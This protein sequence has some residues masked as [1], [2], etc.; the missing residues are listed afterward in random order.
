MIHKLGVIVPYR[1]REQQLS[2]FLP[3]IREYLDGKKILYEIIVVEQKDSYNFNRGTLLNVGALKAE[4]LGCDYVVFHDVDMLPVDVDYSYSEHPL[5]IANRFLQE[6]VPEKQVRQP[7]DYFGG[8]TLFPLFAFK[9]INGYSNEYFGWGFEDNDLLERCREVNSQLRKHLERQVPVNQVGVHFTGREFFEVNN[10]IKR[11]KPF[12]IMVTF[13]QEQL[14]PDISRMSDEGSI[15]SIPGLDFTL[16]FDSFGT[17]KVEAFDTYEDVYS[18]HTEKLPEMVCRA[19][20]TWDPKTG[21]L[22][23]YLNGKQV[24]RKQLKEGRGLFLRGDKIFIGAG[25]PYREGTEK[26]F[27]GTVFNFAVFS[28]VL[29][30]VDVSKLQRV[31]EKILLDFGD[32]LEAFYDFSNITKS[33]LVV[34]LVGHQKG[35]VTYGDVDIEKVDV[36]EVYEEEVPEKRK[37]IFKL[38]FHETHGSTLGYWKSWRSRENQLRFRAV[39]RVGTRYWEDGLSTLQEVVKTK[40]EDEEGPVH[41]IRVWLKEDRTKIGKIYNEI[42]SMCSVQE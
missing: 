31:G 33:G 24:G 37:G 22:S 26:F 11:A 1:D 4:E 42:R 14:K 27:C 41:R 16:S 2:V 15:F 36:G 18:I 10:F 38:Q 29:K 21:S 8:V 23:F 28:K 34:D 13:K 3:S 12:S 32:E 25:N 9:E 35:L 7:F 39:Q 5:Q 17:Y 19:I 20:I 40:R 30:H 6:K